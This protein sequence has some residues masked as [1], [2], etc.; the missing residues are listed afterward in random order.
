MKLTRGLF[1]LSLMVAFVVALS[2]SAQTPP[3]T[4]I[5]QGRFD[6]AR[7]A[8]DA[9]GATQ[10]DIEVAE[11]LI[12]VRQGRRAE[13]IAQLRDILRR[14]PGLI[15]VRRL[16]A[17]QLALDE[18]YAAA[19]FQFQRLLET[20][21]SAANRASYIRAQ[22]ALFSK[23]PFGFS[24]SGA[25]VPSTNINRGTSAEIFPTDFGDF[26]IDED[27][28]GTTG[29]GLA[30][31][32]SVFHRFELAGGQRLQIDLGTG[33]IFYDKPEFNQHSY[34]LRTSLSD[35]KDGRT[36]SIAPEV[37]RTF[38]AGERYYDRIALALAHGWTLT[39]E[40]GLILRAEA[41]YRDYATDTALTGPRYEFETE[42]RRRIDGR[43]SVQTSL[44]YKL[45]EAESAAFQ[46]DGV[47]VGAELRRAFQNGLQIGLGADHEW[48]PYR[49]DFTGVTFPRNDNIT[50]IDFSVFNDQWTVGGAAPTYGCRFTWAQSN[51]AFYDYDVQE[52]SVGFTRNF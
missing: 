5:A 20:D 17:N 42:L 4:L 7:A 2:A 9:Q 21:P 15:T 33:V 39:P 35:T 31:S 47:Q 40:T 36:W 18:Q 10:T 13:A 26:V 38:L 46:Y 49:G 45:G 41:E 22:R 3:G 48:R 8:L 28:L 19:D 11:A 30:L 12:A 16:L 27:N 24:F 37:G 6:E 23:K 29:V 50:S 34:V 44:A 32:G 1:P 52:C 14:E 25:V 51:V 43:T